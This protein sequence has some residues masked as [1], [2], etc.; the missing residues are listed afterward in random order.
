MSAVVSGSR[1][2]SIAAVAGAIVLIGL[3]VLAG[4]FV[5]A[6]P[7]TRTLAGMVTLIEGEV[8]KFDRDVHEGLVAGPISLADARRLRCS[9]I[10][11][12]A[13]VLPGQAIVMYDEDGAV[14]GRGV[15]GPTEPVPV[16]DPTT[17]R[18]SMSCRLPF[19]IDAI[20]RTGNVTF[21]IGDQERRTYT[22]KELDASKWNIE[23]RIDR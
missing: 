8:T 11:T 21:E 3:A 13:K 4:A 15:L 5:T 18:T 1:L 14:L 7:M 6:E 9:T 17:G 22:S 10:S 12:D 2:S 20:E 19:E 23:L 16:A